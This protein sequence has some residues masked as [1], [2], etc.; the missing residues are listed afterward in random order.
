MNACEFDRVFSKNV[1][2]ILEDIFFSLDYNSFKKCLVVSK[3]WNE[4]LTSE[5]SLRRGKSVFCEDIQKELL[6]AAA[7]V[8]GNVD[9]IKR[10]LSTFMVDVNFMT[11]NHASPL[12]Q[13]AFNGRKDVI[14]LLLDRGA[15]PNMADQDG[16]TPLSYALQMG[17]MDVANILTENGGALGGAA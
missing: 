16:M 6:E 1:P 5:S 4:L 10:V 13:A 7:G 12:I 11:E 9:I 3:S 17:H 8:R 15:A 2:H 14:Q